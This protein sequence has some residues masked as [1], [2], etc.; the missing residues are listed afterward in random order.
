MD[1]FIEC[2]WDSD[3]RNEGWNCHMTFS[4]TIKLTVHT[5]KILGQI[6]VTI[7]RPCLDLVRFTSVHL[8]WSGLGWNLVQVPLQP[9]PAHVD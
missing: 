3:R 4:I 8:C 5:P 1:A 9:T 2:Q 6:K 7:V